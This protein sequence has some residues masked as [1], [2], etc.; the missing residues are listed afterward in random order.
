MR[1]DP[2]TGVGIYP[3]II[4]DECM[5]PAAEW[6]DIAYTKGSWHQQ[7]MTRK[8]VDEIFLQLMLTCSTTTLQRARAYFYYGVVRAVGGIFWEGQP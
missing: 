2:H 6:H 8:Q 5:T 3:L 7:N 4:K 1:D